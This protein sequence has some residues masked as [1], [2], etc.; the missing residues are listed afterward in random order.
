MADRSKVVSIVVFREQGGPIVGRRRD[1][2]KWSVLVLRPKFIRSHAREIGD[3][4]GH[5]D[6]HPRRPIYVIRIFRNT[7]EFENFHYR[8]RSLSPQNIVPL[9]LLAISNPS[10]LLNIRNQLSG[11]QY[12]YPIDRRNSRPYTWLR[13]I[14]HCGWA[15]GKH[16]CF[17]RTSAK[18]Q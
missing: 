10:C 5:S 1:G 15:K 2:R 4:D 9:L 6:L 8:L 16:T 14:I 13:L 17:S 18:R 7:I 12:T 11:R 3:A